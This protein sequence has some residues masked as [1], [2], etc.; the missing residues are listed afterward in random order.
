MGDREDAA[1]PTPTFLSAAPDFP[2]PVTDPLPGPGGSQ[3]AMPS[4]VLCSAT[5]R[6]REVTTFGLL[7]VCV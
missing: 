7:C 3:E 2:F 4:A 6:Y 5:S 1:G